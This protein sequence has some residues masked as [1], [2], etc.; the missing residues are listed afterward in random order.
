M[1][2]G[3]EIVRPGGSP[4]AVQIVGATAPE[5]DI[6]RKYWTPTAPS[7]RDGVV[8]AIWADAVSVAS[9]N[10][11][12]NRMIGDYISVGRRTAE[13]TSLQST[14]RTGCLP[15]VPPTQR[16]ADSLERRRLE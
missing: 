13:I 2:P 15:H 6:V 7:G 5:E 16:R 3:V 10:V 12:H 8:M 14:L 4:V 1:L 9:Q 11:T